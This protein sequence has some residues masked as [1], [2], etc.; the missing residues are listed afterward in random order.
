MTGPLRHIAGINSLILQSPGNDQHSRATKPCPPQGENR[1]SHLFD[2]ART[3]TKS[4]DRPDPFVFSSSQ[5]SNPVTAITSHEACLLVCLTRWLRG[6]VFLTKYQ[7]SHK[8]E[9]A[10]NECKVCGKD[11]EVIVAEMLDNGEVTSVYYCV[12]HAPQSLMLSNVTA[13]LKSDAM[14][15]IASIRRV[16]E[17]IDK[18]GTVPTIAEMGRLGVSGNIV[19][20]VE[21]FTGAMAE[22]RSHLNAGCEFL[23]EHIKTFGND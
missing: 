13:Q 14:A 10:L 20:A 3:G 7:E 6:G 5:L 21:H 23:S 19:F 17:F 1:G 11:A 2:H 9:V 22:L 15:T 8:C 4:P 12:T 16:N 18:M